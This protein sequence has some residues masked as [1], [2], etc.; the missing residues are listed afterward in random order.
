MYGNETFARTLLLNIPV[1]AAC[2]VKLME[3]LCTFAVFKRVY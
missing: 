2:V 3:V 1:P